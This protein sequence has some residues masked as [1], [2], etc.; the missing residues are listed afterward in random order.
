MKKLLPILLFLLGTG[1]GVGA[2]IFVAPTDSATKSEPENGRIANG[3]VETHQ[4]QPDKKKTYQENEHA[5]SGHA[6]NKE[7]N[8]GEESAELDYVKLNN[9]FVVP[10]VASNRVEALVVLSLSIEAE[11]GLRDE[12]YAREPKI[13]DAF[14]Q[15]LFDHANVGGF[16]GA[17]TRANNLDTLRSALTEVAR[18]QFGSGIH[19]VLIIDIARQDV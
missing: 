8:H 15:V 18:G 14:L 11:P 1:A 19:N 9:Q 7:N 13:R 2:G 12:I 16:Q 4:D 3:Q 10:V 5:A 17:F 6:G